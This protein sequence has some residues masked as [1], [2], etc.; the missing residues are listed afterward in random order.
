MARTVFDLLMLVVCATIII[1]ALTRPLDP[2]RT[3]VIIG[4]SIIIGL[5]RGVLLFNRERGRR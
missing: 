1:L 3:T 4:A 5:R 2:V